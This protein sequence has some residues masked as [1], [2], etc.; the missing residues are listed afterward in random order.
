MPK[1]QT[2]SPGPAL[3]P[4]NARQRRFVDG[5]LEGRPPGEAATA[6][7]YTGWA[8]S[9]SAYEL[10]RRP[11]VAA[12]IAAGRARQGRGGLSREAA[13]EELARVAMSNIL[14]YAEVRRGGQIE[15][16]LS[17]IDR[18]RAAGMR[19]L[20]LD[21]TYNHRTGETLRRVRV[22]MGPKLA[23]LRSLIPLLPTSA[24]LAA[25]EGAAGAPEA[26]ASGPD[27]SRAPPGPPPDET[28]TD[29]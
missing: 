14:D 3:R 29:P 13:I 28:L 22:R 4:L 17:R 11:N 27:P 20:I 7:G 1:S 9:Q 26:A 12:A 15:I 21:E 8:A 19:E 5:I 25:A 2:P 18:A 6:A 24:E 10:A 23:A 16:D